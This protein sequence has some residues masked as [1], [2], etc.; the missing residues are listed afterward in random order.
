MFCTKYIGLSLF[1][2]LFSLT[3]CMENKKKEDNQEARNL[4]NESS[5]LIIKSKNNILNAQDS[6]A[7]DSII[8]NFDKLITDINFRYPALT[9]LKLTEQENDSILKLMSELKTIKEK[10]L[11]E[12]SSVYNS[13]IDSI[14]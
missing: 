5:Q 1:V 13:D 12:L 7:I 10:K 11:E 2:V 9:D 6:A 8:D 14:N 4:F 3:S